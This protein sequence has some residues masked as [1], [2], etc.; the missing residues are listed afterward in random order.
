MPRNVCNSVQNVPNSCGIDLPYWQCV[1]IFSSILEDSDYSV[2]AFIS[3]FPFGSD[4][5]KSP[6]GLC[7]GLPVATCPDLALSFRRLIF[8][9]EREGLLVFEFCSVALELLRLPGF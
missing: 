8:A 9:S 6:E 2:L 1:A 7:Q 3:P 4:K 5:P